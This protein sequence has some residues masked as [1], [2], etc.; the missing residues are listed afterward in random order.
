M[1][2]KYL[3][4]SRPYNPRM[5]HDFVEYNHVVDEILQIS[6]P[7]ISESPYAPKYS[8]PEIKPGGISTLPVQA[9]SNQPIGI[10]KILLNSEGGRSDLYQMNG[11]SKGSFGGYPG[12]LHECK[13]SHSFDSL[14]E[15]M[16]GSKILENK[17]SMKGIANVIK[18]L[19]NVYNIDEEVPQQPASLKGDS[20]FKNF[21]NS[22]NPFLLKQ[23]TS[24]NNSMLE[25][26]NGIEGLK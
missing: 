18:N 2:L 7:Y 25:S 3:E 19:Q 17:K 10:H 12:F 23:E 5:E 8:A 24:K 26:K 16:N 1:N 6:P 22:N 4:L 14:K 13:N 20:L 15:V 21:G 9:Q 11:F